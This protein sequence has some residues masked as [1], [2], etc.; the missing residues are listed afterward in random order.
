VSARSQ[1]AALGPASTDT[2]DEIRRRILA[3][4]AAAETFVAV[5]AEND[6]GSV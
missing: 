5:H 2:E 6:G 3:S 4:V 1:I